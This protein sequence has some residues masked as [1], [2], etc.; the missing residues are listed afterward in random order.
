MKRRDK[1]QLKGIVFFTYQAEDFRL[2]GNGVKE[3]KAVKNP[4]LNI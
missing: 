1:F 3:N 4:N 2:I